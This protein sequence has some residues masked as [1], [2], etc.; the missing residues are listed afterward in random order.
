LT[1]PACRAAAYPLTGKNIIFRGRVAPSDLPSCYRSSDIFCSVAVGSESFGIVL[2]EAMASGVPVIATA[3]DGYREIITDGVEGMLVKPGDGAALT[4]ALGKL[5][6]DSK[7]RATMGQR[8]RNKAIQ[9]DWSVVAARISEI[10]EDLHCQPVYRGNS[11]TARA[12]SIRL[13]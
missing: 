1:E 13:F 12:R 2:L 8:G 6:E 10:Y 5:A 4:D 9:F 7:L 11:E 3:I